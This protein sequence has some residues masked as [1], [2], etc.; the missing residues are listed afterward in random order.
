MN[1]KAI[2]DI[3]LEFGVTRRSYN[4][5]V[6]QAEKDGLVEIYKSAYRGP[7]IFP[8]RYPKLSDVSATEANLMEAHFRKI[9]FTN[10]IGDLNRQ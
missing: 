4:K 9:H 3:M 7:V 5:L 8:I 10:F 2:G 6:K 1:V